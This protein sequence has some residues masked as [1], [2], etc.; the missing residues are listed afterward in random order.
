MNRIALAFSA[1]SSLLSRSS[2]S[3]AGL[4]WLRKARLLPAVI[5]S[6]TIPI[7]ASDRQKR[8]SGSAEFVGGL[9]MTSANRRLRRPFRISLSGFEERISRH[10]R[11][12]LSGMR[13][14]CSATNEGRPASIGDFR[15]GTDP[16]RRGYAGRGQVELRRRRHE[17][18]R[19]DSYGVVRTHPSHCANLRS[20]LKT[21][22]QSHKTCPLPIPKDE[23][24]NNRGIETIAYAPASGPLHGR[25]RCGN[26]KEHQ[27]GGRYVRRSA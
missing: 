14:R 4:S 10:Y 1:R 6:R 20:T 22:R 13:A 23:L 12:W 26:R 5:T 25:A 17:R 3:L 27:R 21:L 19:Q 2:F 18:F 24:R 7:S 15:L 11:Y 16:E 9:E 8:I